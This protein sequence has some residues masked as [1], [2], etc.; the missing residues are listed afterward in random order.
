M[1]SRTISPK[2]NFTCI[3]YHQTY[4]YSITNDV[5]TPPSSFK[6][7]LTLDQSYRKRERESLRCPRYTRECFNT[8]ISQA[9]S[10]LEEIPLARNRPE[11][12]PPLSSKKK[13]KKKEISLLHPPHLPFSRKGITDFLLIFFHRVFFSPPKIQRFNF[14]ASPLRRISGFDHHYPSATF[15]NFH[16]N[17]TIN[18][19]TRIRKSH[20]PRRVPLSPPPPHKSYLTQPHVEIVIDRAASA[21]THK[22]ERATRT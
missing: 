2:W 6:S 10:I 22:P 12:H 7:I 16:R 3:I 19:F 17:P 11:A 21:V 18:A 9:I 5:K 1:Q 13:E 15:R 20:K 8:T 4:R 14:P